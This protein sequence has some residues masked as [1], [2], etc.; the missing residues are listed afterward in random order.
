MAS[1]RSFL[2]VNGVSTDLW[3]GDRRRKIVAERQRSMIFYAVIPAA[4]LFF[5]GSVSLVLIFLRLIG[6]RGAAFLTL[7]PAVASQII[8]TY[9]YWEIHQKMARLDDFL[10]EY[11]KES[12]GRDPTAILLATVATFPGDVF[13]F[14]ISRGEGPTRMRISREGLDNTL[15]VILAPKNSKTVVHLREGKETL[16]PN[17]AALQKAYPGLEKQMRAATGAKS[18]K[19]EGFPIFPAWHAAETAAVAAELKV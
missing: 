4:L 11:Y 7:A 15:R 14:C 18:P 16:F 12:G 17:I 10:E 9:I 5:G 13:L 3:Y 19:K 8:M 2:A 6:P 1:L